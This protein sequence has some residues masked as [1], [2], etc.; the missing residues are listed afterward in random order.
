MVLRN[1]LLTPNRT[2]APRRF[3][4]PAKRG[5]GLQGGCC[6]SM[7]R[8]STKC[9]TG[10]VRAGRCC[11]LSSR[12]QPLLWKLCTLLARNDKVLMLL[13]Q[14]PQTSSPALSANSDSRGPP[15]FPPFP[16]FRFS[17]FLLRLA[18][19]PSKSAFSLSLFERIFDVFAS[20]VASL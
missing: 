1:A 10:V 2:T 18:L 17:F 15:F 9:G 19:L 20:M 3:A 4:S 7:T 6:S 8:T 14:S 5:A 16:P 11:S 12:T 13:P